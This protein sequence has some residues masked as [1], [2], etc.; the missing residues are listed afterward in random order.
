ME[1]EN[2]SFEWGL[3]TLGVVSL[4]FALIAFSNPASGLMA[5]VVIFAL[6]AILKGIFEITFRRRISHFRLMNKT[7]LTVL[8]VIEIIIGIVLLLN[9]W[10]GV[11]AI[12]F[13][14]AIWIITDSIGA[15]FLSSA[16]RGVSNAMFWFILILAIIGLIIG[17]V[18][19]F[20]PVGGLFT[21]AFLVG[22]YFMIAG[23][24]S[25]VE[26]F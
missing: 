13:I 1:D 24:T 9:L 20:N 16:F 14:F 26:A 11:L 23:I 22:M 10:L 7:G 8:G 19:L 5:I 12:P 25:I 15:L 17:V 18:L 21:V 4:I 3:F 2:Q 6:G